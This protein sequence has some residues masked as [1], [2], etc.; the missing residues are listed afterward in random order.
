MAEQEPTFEE[1]RA[2]THLCRRADILQYISLKI[3]HDRELFT[4]NNP[5]DELDKDLKTEGVLRSAQILKNQASERQEVRGE[6]AI[7]ADHLLDRT[8]QRALTARQRTPY[9]TSMTTRVKTLQHL[10]KD[11]L[12]SL[13][14]IGI[15]VVDS[16]VTR[17]IHTPGNSHQARK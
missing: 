6:A 2:Y 8:H 15:T 17:Q 13:L 9:E 12:T 5:L 7:I 10:G 4:S 11:D 14:A 3:W 1:Q 16:F